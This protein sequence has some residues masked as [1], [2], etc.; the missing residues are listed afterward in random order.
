MPCVDGIAI[1]GE[2]PEAI[3]IRAVGTMQLTVTRV[4]VRGALHG[5]HLV[6]NIWKRF[7]MYSVNISRFFFARSIACVLSHFD[8]PFEEEYSM[9]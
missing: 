2:H 5:I 6:E 1:A 4:H 7:C 8:P 9:Y 3:G